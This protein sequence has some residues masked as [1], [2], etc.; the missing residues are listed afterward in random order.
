MEHG[1][2]K[3][4]FSQSKELYS[5]GKYEES[6][7]VLQELNEEYPGTKNILFPMALNLR[8]LGRFDEALAV[9]DEVILQFDAEKAHKL[10]DDILND[11]DGAATLD[12]D[13]NDLTGNLGNVGGVAG[14]DMDED[15]GGLDLASLNAGIE[16]PVGS[17]APVIMDRGGSDFNWGQTLG[18]VFGIIGLFVIGTFV[19]F[20]FVQGLKEGVPGE[21]GS[22]NSIAFTILFYVASAVFGWALQ[23]I[24]MFVTLMIMGSLPEPDLKGNATNIA[25]ISFVMLLI[26]LIPMV[27]S[28]A[29]L[30]FFVNT[31]DIGFSGC[32]VYVIISAL[33]IAGLVALL[34]ALLIASGIDI[35]S[36]ETSMR[37]GEAAY[38][39][40]QLSIAQAIRPG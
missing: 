15:A 31:Y 21:G 26:Q 1:D 11:M 17:T 39:Y 2:S 23:C 25:V 14:V 16:E 34:F 7:S 9:C 32:I 38:A 40:A 35:D 33:A 12:P 22:E 5:E 8:A 20:A 37:Q 24:V 29:S 19:A 4:K 30:I 10:R 18:I 3:A 27:G 36:I 6:L 13:L 28:I